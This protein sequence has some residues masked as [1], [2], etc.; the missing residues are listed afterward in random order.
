MSRRG[1][2]VLTVLVIAV[3]AAVGSGRAGSVAPREEVPVAKPTMLVGP[4][5]PLTVRGLRFK[6]WERVTVTLDGGS[7]G[8]A[9]V[10]ANRAGT[11]RAEFRIRLRACR[12]VTIRAVGSRGSRAV[13]QLPRPDCREP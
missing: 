11:F 4:L 10:L 9:R 5:M 6:A 12:T 2:G 3:L 8:T 1:I 7:R 13:R